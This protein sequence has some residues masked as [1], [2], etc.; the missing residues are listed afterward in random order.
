MSSISV[1]A[2]HLL[3]RAGL[4]QPGGG[5]RVRAAA[6]SRCSGC[7]MLRAGSG[8]DREPAWRRGRRVRV[9]CRHGRAHRRGPPASSRVTLRVEAGVARPA[10]RR[11]V[12]CCGSGPDCWPPRHPAVHGSGERA[13]FFLHD[14][15][16]RGGAQLRRSMAP[17]AWS[18][19]SCDPTAA[20]RRCWMCGGSRRGSTARCCDKLTRCTATMPLAQAASVIAA[21]RTGCRPAGSAACRDYDSRHRER[22]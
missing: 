9:F 13:L 17:M 15:L 8:G 18:R 22:A 20:R 11:P 16:E 1:T 19:C 4:V 5:R 6:G 12:L 7:W 10:R 21:D 3:G 14:G 2:V